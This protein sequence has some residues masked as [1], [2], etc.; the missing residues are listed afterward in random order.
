M[1]SSILTRLP[2]A[3]P[4][5]I[6]YAAVA[7]LA[8]KRMQRHPVPSRL[9]LLACAVLIAGCVA[10]NSL[11]AYFDYMARNHLGHESDSDFF[12]HYGWIIRYACAIGIASLAAGMGL[13]FKAVY[14][15]RE[16][17]SREAVPEVSGE[18]RQPRHGLRLC[19]GKPRPSRMAAGPFLP[20]SPRRSRRPEIPIPTPPGSP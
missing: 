3:A 6:V 10:G 1:L 2:Y 13:L 15:D 9:A 12:A 16:G 18:P 5:L 8:A 14:T 20:N 11:S 4:H 17:A 7:V 19:P